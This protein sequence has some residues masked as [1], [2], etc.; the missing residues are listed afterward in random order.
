MGRDAAEEQV[1]KSRSAAGDLR[2]KNR[3]DLTE[4]YHLP[5]LDLRV[6]RTLPLGEYTCLIVD[7]ESRTSA[8][9]EE[10]CGHRFFMKL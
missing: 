8:R 3:R 10:S 9:L 6:T 5:R 4:E 1:E 7:R 2:E